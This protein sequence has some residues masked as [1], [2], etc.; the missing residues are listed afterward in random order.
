[1]RY[2]KYIFTNYDNCLEIKLYNIKDFLIGKYIDSWK[3]YYKNR[4]NLLQKSQP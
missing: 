3:E 4:K 1:M 2:F